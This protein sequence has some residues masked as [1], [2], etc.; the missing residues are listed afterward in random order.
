LDGSNPSNESTRYTG[1]LTI[2]ADATLK[3]I[4]Y[5]END[6]ESSIVSQDFTQVINESAKTVTLVEDVSELS[7]G[8]QV[9]IV[10]SESDVALS[11]VQNTNNRGQAGI[12]KNGNNVE[13]SPNVQI[14]TLEAG[15]VAGTFAFYTGSGYLHAASSKE[16]YLKTQSTNNE[17]GS[18]SIAIADGVA[19][20][21]ANGSY[22]RNWL[23]YNNNSNLF[24]CYGSG[25]QDVSLYKINYNPY[26]LNVS[27][28]GWAT[29][30]LDYTAEIP[31]GVTCYVISE[32]GAE[33][34]QLK[35]V[36]DAV[37]ANTAVIVE[38]AKG[39]YTFEVA[40][41]A[42]D[43]ESD[44]TGTTKN[45]YIPENVYVLSI[46]DDEVGLYKAEMNGGVF[47]NNANKAYLPANAVPDAVQGASG[48]KFRFE[49]TGVEQV[50]VAKGVK[51][52]Y[53][54]SGRK[55]NDMKAPGL[56]IVNGKKVLVK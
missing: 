1:P 10:A 5:D 48:F 14:L 2:K 44:M 47:L 40:D 37:P 41:E 7:V 50:E 11:N 42:A 35:E 49:T 32:F 25:Q 22:T 56:Y 28:A 43:I 6:N 12:T 27:E 18:W 53:D 9:V 30:F 8:N 38:A 39:A 13:L 54:L 19:T 17:N 21:K 3:V 51:A 45:A 23:R 29:L 20:I 34:I 36:E 24:S 55:V 4:A 15:T 31:E 46:V 33:T 52:I 26:V 16:N